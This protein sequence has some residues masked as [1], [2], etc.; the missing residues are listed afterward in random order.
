MTYS[1][2]LFINIYH[3][4]FQ[5]KFEFYGP[6][7]DSVDHFLLILLDYHYFCLFLAVRVFPEEYKVY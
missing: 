2:N 3:I 1:S 5:E 4:P 6:F 7:K